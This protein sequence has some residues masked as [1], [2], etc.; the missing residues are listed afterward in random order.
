MFLCHVCGSTVYHEETV[1]E[2]FW[3]DGQP[4]L[5]ENI[6]ARICNHCSEAVFSPE[7]AETIRQMVHGEMRPVKSIAMD[8]FEY[9]N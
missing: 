6:P 8:V 7:V 4:L 3:I 5:V 2:I 9:T 1:Q